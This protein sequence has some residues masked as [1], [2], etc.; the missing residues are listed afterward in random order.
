ME[1]NMILIGNLKLAGAVDN[2]KAKKG[3]LYIYQHQFLIERHDR[4]KFESDK[5][6]LV[7]LIN[8]QYFVGASKSSKLIFKRWR[9][10]STYVCEK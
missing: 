1:I 10:F 4:H 7:Y 2:N 8:Y 3:K 6:G 9:Q 5:N